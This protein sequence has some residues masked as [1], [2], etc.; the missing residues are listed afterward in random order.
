MITIEQLDAPAVRAKAGELAQLLLDAHASGMALGL[1]APLTAAGAREAYLQTA[2]RL[3]PGEHVL[4]VAL[5]RDEVVGAVQVDRAK[6]PN[7]RHRA[8]LRRLVVRAD[9]RGSGIGRALV[10]AATDHARAAGLRLLWL[11]TH[12]GTVAE[13]VY[14]QL[15]W[16]RSGVIEDWATLPDG[17]LASNAFFYLRL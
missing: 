11:T 16:Q 5:D 13:R 2:E 8:E 12:E 15:G 1:A 4:L 9:R 7:G 10:E 3:E 6:A 17:T 14:E